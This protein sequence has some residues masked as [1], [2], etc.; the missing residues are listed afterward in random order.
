M[1]KVIVIVLISLIL[2]AAA[3]HGDESKL[4]YWRWNLTGKYEKEF[5]CLL[6]I[7]GYL[8]AIEV[9]KM[10][11]ISPEIMGTEEASLKTVEEYLLKQIPDLRMEEYAKLVMYHIEIMYME[12]KF[13]EAD[14]PTVFAAAVLE[15]ANEMSDTGE[16]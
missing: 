6:M 5:H 13:R 3:G 1:K 4:F 15:I 2:G 14:F 16:E 11:I 8:G 12:G 9:I 7:R 10:S